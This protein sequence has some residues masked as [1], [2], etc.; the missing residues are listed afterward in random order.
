M[1]GMAAAVERIEAVAGGEKIL[2]F[3]DY[4]VDGILS[5]VMLHKALTSLGGQVDYFIPERLKDGYGIKDE[6]IAVASSAA[7]GLVI[8][9]D[10]G[11]KAGGFVRPGRGA[12]AWMSS[13]PTT[14]CPA[15]SSLPRWP[16]SIPV[17]EGAGLSR[18]QDLAG[19]GV[20][21]KL[22]Q[23]LLDKTGQAGGLPA[24]S[25]AGGASAPISDIA[26]LKGE[27]RLFAKIGLRSWRTSPIPVS[28]LIDV[29]GLG[30]KEDLR[31]RRRL[32]HRP[33]DQR[34]RPDGP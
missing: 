6:H 29:C 20:V 19:V 3:G 15:Q 13:S 22:I 28:S 2:I 31:G 26:E 14:T 10:C 24:L 30:G 11:I 16:S 21:F 1:K 33:A 23:A 17:A 8:S 12:R 27:N 32:P 25:Q 5:M 18:P 7:P 9:V 4:D 34:R